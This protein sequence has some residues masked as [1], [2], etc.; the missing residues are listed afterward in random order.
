[1]EWNRVEIVLS[2]GRKLVCLIRGIINA[3]SIMIAIMIEDRAY[4]SKNYT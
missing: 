1:M 3:V 4:V 2:H